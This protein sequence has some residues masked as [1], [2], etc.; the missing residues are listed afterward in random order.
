[1]HIYFAQAIPLIAYIDES[2]IYLKE[3]KCRICEAVCKNDAIDFNQVAENMEIKV[4]AV[5]LSPGLEPFDPKL[6]AEYRYGEYE[7]V[8][9][10]L[11]YERLL[12]S[13][14]PYQGEIRRTSD[15]KHPRNVAW[16]QCV[17]SSRSWREPTATALPYAAPIRRNR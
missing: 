10:S 5:I 2:C 6:R 15:L 14:G 8:M 17:G 12:S 11:D 4:G 16:I 13:T 1:M 9:T 7:N 3:K